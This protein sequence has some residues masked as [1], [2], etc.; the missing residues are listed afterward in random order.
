MKVKCYNLYCH[1]SD[2]DHFCTRE[3]IQLWLID[4]HNPQSKMGCSMFEKKGS[5]LFEYIF[6]WKDGR[7]EKEIA[8]DVCMALCH[9]DYD[10]GDIPDLDYWFSSR[11]TEESCSDDIKEKR[12]GTIL[13]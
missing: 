9:K 8:S 3:E 6:H 11:E 5:K 2:K 12:R 4:F 1:F 13:L 7:V 10:S